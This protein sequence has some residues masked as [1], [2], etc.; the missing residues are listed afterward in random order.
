MTSTTEGADVARTFDAGAEQYDALLR[1]NREGALRLVASLPQGDYRTLLDVGCGTGFVTEAMRERFPGLRR[2]IGVDPSEQMLARFH[3][4]LAGLPG[5]EV[6]LHQAGVGGMP[7]PDGSADAVLTGMA[8]HWFPDKPAA[9][10]AMARALAPGGV[11]GILAA[12]R[13]TDEE[14]RQIM[15]GLDPPPPAAWTEVYA[16][17]HRDARELTGYMR[18][19]GLEPVDVWEERRVRTTSP[20]SYLARIQAVSAHLSQGMDPA[21]LEAEGSRLAGAVTAA[22]GPE[23]FAYSFT[24]LYGIARRPR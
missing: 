15:L 21:R 17:I 24:K 12:G 8:F 3:D 18:D 6:E 13:G 22:A 11:L 7:V 14:L 10:A 4:K 19:A 20:E 16:H 2:V 1:H 9:V 5:L 23:G